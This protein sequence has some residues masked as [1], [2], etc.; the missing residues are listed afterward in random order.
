PYYAPPG[1]RV[2]EDGKTIIGDKAQE[3]IDRTEVKLLGEHN[4][5][6]ICAALTAVQEVVGS[7]DKARAVLSGFS[8]VEHRLELVREFAGTKYYDDSFGTTP[9]TSIV[10]IKT[11]SEPKILILGGS[12]KG[13]SY[14]EL[15][16]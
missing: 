16:K 14:D 6:N 13:A 12:D 5:Q 2:R 4:L 11:F 3:I 15:A 8:G 9:D 1:A 10:A 7:L